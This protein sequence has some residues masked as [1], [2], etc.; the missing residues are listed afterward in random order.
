MSSAAHV[1]LS[2][3]PG[4]AGQ[5]S[6][7][8]EIVLINGASRT[9]KGVHILLSRS[10]VLFVRAFSRETP[11]TVFEAWDKAFDF[12]GGAWCLGYVPYRQVWKFAWGRGVVPLLGRAP[13][14]AD[15]SGIP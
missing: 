8:R 10:L 12:F 15:H 9:V 1:P 14:G 4:D 3:D 6:L 13:A 5:F 11:K 7:R 2:F